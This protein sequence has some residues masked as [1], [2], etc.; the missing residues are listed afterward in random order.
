MSKLTKLGLVSLAMVGM[1][2]SSGCSYTK[3][4]APGVG[5]YGLM[6]EELC[7]QDYVILDT[8]E[9]K[10]SVTRILWF[11]TLGDDQFG[12]VGNEGLG[13]PTFFQALA[14]IFVGQP[15]DARAAA[16]Y[17]ALSKL[18]EA[19]TFLPM[20]RTASTTGLPGFFEGLYSVTE[21]T[22]RGKALRVKPGDGKSCPVRTQIKIK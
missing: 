20:T 10:G 14:S 8:V 2:V 18:P 5:L 13:G 7:R 21:A 15:R 19:D 22:V 1:I 4:R 3:Q 12:F 17:D 11:I 9:G 16:T 6:M